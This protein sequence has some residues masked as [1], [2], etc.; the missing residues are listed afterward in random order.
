M[1]GP[2]SLFQKP[3]VVLQSLTLGSD[4]TCLVLTRSLSFNLW[5]TPILQL[6]SRTWFVIIPNVMAKN[7]HNLTF[8]SFYQFIMFS[9]SLQSVIEL[10]WTSLPPGPHTFCLQICHFLPCISQIQYSFSFFWL[11]LIYAFC[12]SSTCYTLLFTITSIKSLPSMPWW[13]LFPILSFWAYDFSP[14]SLYH[15]FPLHNV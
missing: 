6:L 5:V 9:Y 7:P 12:L 14:I 15:V 8:P 4:P 1:Q 3:V 10:F 13:D 11:P 2:F